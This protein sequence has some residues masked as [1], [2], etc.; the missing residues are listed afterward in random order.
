MGPGFL[1]AS[2]SLQ[3]S[4]YTQVHRG[5]GVEQDYDGG[6]PLGLFTIEQGRPDVEG[7]QKPR[8]N[9]NADCNQR[10]NSSSLGIHRRNMVLSV[11]RRKKGIR[12]MEGVMFDLVL[13]KGQAFQ[14]RMKGDGRRSRQG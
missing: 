13:E 1:L 7:D 10:F 4:H 3:C 8:Q 5:D 9:A 14:S 12:L 2:N 6:L 11:E